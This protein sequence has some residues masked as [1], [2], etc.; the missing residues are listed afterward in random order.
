MIRRARLSTRW[1]MVAWLTVVWVL[2]WGNLTV[3]NV[4][5]GLALGIL[6][7]TVAPMPRVGLDG[8]PWLPGIVPLLVRF[9]ADVVM[10]SVQVAIRALS[11][12]RPPRGAVVRVQLRSHSDLL[13]TLTAQLC[14]LVPGSIIVEAHRLTGTL[15]VH[16]LDVKAAGGIDGAREHTLAIERRV[17]Y[18]FATD[19]EIAEAGLPPRKRLFRR[20]RH[21]EGAHP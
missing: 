5:A 2:L 21:P 8:R 16:V 11:F 17:M 13:L 19:A 18:A 1:P 9:A 7:V 3:A 12:G 10:A 20:R 6:L 15:Y 14:S 4:L